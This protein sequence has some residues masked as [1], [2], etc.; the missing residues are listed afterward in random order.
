MSERKKKSKKTYQITK[1]YTNIIS[2]L[3]GSQA[4]A[5]SYISEFHT[6]KTAARAVACSSI[7]LSGM[8]I[9]MSPLAMLLIP[10]DWTWH[11]YSLN[12]KPWR[13]FLI[14]NSFINLLNGIVFAFLPEG[15]KFLL[16]INEHEKALQVLRQVYAFN[17]GKPEQVILYV[18]LAK[19]LL[20]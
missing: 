5:F 20:L 6:T 13:L 12:F 15:P 14:S 7:L 3:A 16:A 8:A 9:F 17:T 10:M 11:I 2:S 4:G 19:V 18:C 1:I